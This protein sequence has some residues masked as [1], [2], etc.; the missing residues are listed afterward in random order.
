MKTIITRA[1]G[2]TKVVLSGDPFQVD[3]AFLD[4]ASNGLVYVTE[5]LK[6]SPMTG[7][8]MFTKGER[9]PLAELAA[10]YL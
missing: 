4:S 2:G 3:N 7:A 9:S 10:T 8:V 1:A 5:R 6:S